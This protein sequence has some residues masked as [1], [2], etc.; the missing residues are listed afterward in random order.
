MMVRGGSRSAVLPHSPGESS[1]AVVALT[2]RAEVD[3]EMGHGLAGALYDEQAWAAGEI[4]RKAS[5]GFAEEDYVPASLARQ[6][7]QTVV[8]DMDAMRS[9]SD[10][11]SF[12]HSGVLGL[13]R[14]L[15]QR[16]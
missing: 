9:Y 14:V 3:A 12:I 7:L 11:S 5:A 15:L 4:L 16:S 6:R 2:P 1:S 13:S 10:P 8:A